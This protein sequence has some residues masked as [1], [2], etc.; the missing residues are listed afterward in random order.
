MTRTFNMAPPLLGKCLGSG[1]A[2]SVVPVHG[3]RVF[4][5]GVLYR[6]LL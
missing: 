2:G 3:P 1:L 4:S 5:D 6:L